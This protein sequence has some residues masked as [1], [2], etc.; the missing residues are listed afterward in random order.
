[1]DT[2]RVT[3]T[4]E[5]SSLNTDSETKEYVY[6]SF[7][8]CVPGGGG[9]GPSAPAFSEK[10]GDLQPPGEIRVTGI[11]HSWDAAEGASE[12]ERVV[13]VTKVSS[14]NINKFTE[15]D[16]DFSIALRQKI[17]EMEERE[18]KIEEKAKELIDLVKD[19]DED[20]K[21]KKNKKM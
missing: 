15:E 4:V 8:S 11:S 16:L 1:M 10:Y 5:D 12:C 13:R 19:P 20:I 7:P 9:G 14:S 18:R 2:F 21:P 17:E 3:L 6:D